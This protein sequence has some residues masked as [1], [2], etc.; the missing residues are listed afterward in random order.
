MSATTRELVLLALANGIETPRQ[1]AEAVRLELRP[2][3]NAIA[4]LR[5]EGLVDRD[6]FRSQI[7]SVERYVEHAQAGSVPSVE[8]RSAS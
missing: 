7:A 4:R 8:H 1:I 3:Q 2:V 5:T 6:G